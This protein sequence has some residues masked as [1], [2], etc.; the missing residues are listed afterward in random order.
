MVGVNREVALRNLEEV[1]RVL[2]RLKVPYW[3]DCGTLL[4]V[5]RQGDFLPHDQDIDFGVWGADKHKETAEKILERGFVKG[6]FYGTP[7]H[8]YEQSFS[9]DGVKVDIFYF[10]PLGGKRVWQGSWLG[11]HLIES[12]FDRDTV[13][14]PVPM[15]FRG[16][17]TFGPHRPDRMLE[18]RY[19]DW[20][21][22]VKEWDWTRDP[23]CITKETRPHASR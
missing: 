19:G 1:N 18:A 9:R 15:L 17:E 6:R 16:I 14:P 4:G 20:T 10:Y 12:V 23:L 22:E 5:I 3:I 21:Q 13:L 8:G 2:S 11:P 7:E